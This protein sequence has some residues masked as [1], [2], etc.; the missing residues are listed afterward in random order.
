M[1]LFRGL[2]LMMLDASSVAVPEGFQT[3]ANGFI[4]DMGPD[5]GYHNPTLVLVAAAHRALRGAR[6]PHAAP[7][8]A[9]TA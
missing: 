1:L 9:S 5:T 7:T 4:P 6:V 8:C 3:I 2:D